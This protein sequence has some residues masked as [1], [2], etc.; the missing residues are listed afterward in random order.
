MLHYLSRGFC[1][2]LLATLFILGGIP[3]QAA[4]EVNVYS[5]RQPYLINPL[6]EAFTKKTGIKVNTIFADKGLIERMAA[7]GRNSPADVLLTADIGFLTSAVDQGVTQAVD[8]PVINA[9]IPA[10][11]RDPAGHWFGL[12]AR[13]RVVYASK[14]RVK[15]DKVTYEDLADPKWKGRICIRSG[16]HP[17][18]VALTASMIAQHG[19]EKTKAWLTGLRDNLAVK[20]AGGDRDQAKAIYAGQ[21]DIG[22]GNTY[23]I[24]ILAS[25][26]KEP[27]GQKWAGAV[28]ILFPNTA[29]RG[30]H[31]NISGM[32]MAKY[33]PHRD[34]AL[35]L[36]EFLSTA[37][38]QGIY[39][40][41]NYEFPLKEGV[42]PAPIVAAWGDF[43]RD[44]RPIAEIANL[45]KRASEL[46]DEV[47]FDQ[48]PS[49]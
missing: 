47:K 15:E 46:I 20:P 3:A 19:E 7:E 31:M 8:S 32:V 25:N 35:K 12:T 14:E 26:D 21:C 48:G 41:T 39:A 2:A 49:S 45:R 23:Y 36:M 38:A 6:L 24:A 9:N 11:Y 22:I 37:E 5:L 13:A 40:Q 17:Y 1:C 42:A 4:E 16:Q 18:N 27:E 44:A 10:Q 33:A 30:T 43:K 34:A 29:D 28:K